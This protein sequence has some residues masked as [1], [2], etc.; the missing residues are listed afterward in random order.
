MITA[1]IVGTEG[2]VKNL[3]ELTPTI[4]ERLRKEFVKLLIQMQTHVKTNKLSGQVLHRRTSNLSDAIHYDVKEDE[5]GLVGR[6]Y[7][8][9]EAPYG[10]VHEYGG[11]FQIPGHQ[12]MMRKAWGRIVRNPRLI[13]IKPHLAYYVERSF[14]RT[15]LKEFNTKF[16]ER[17]LS[18]L[19]KATGKP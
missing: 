16:R 11:L 6:L 5:A 9:P 3:K 12:R 14:M 13:N 8:G 2:I 19:Q 18:V 10:K 4:R 15:T 1:T 7:V 17:V